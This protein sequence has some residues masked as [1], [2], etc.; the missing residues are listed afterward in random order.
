M[1][2]I[3]VSLLFLLSV[4]SA[5]AAFAGIPIPYG[6]AQKL[7]FVSE[8]EIR[9]SQNRLLSLC[10]LWTRQHL[11]YVGY[12]GSQVYVLAEN[13]CVD[14]GYYEYAQADLI[15]DRIA[16]IVPA[17][18]SDTPPINL[19]FLAYCFTAWGAAGII[20]LLWANGV[21]AE[22]S[23]LKRR[24]KLLGDVHPFVERMVTVMTH[25][26]RADGN[27]SDVEIELMR[28]T[29]RDYAGVPVS[30]EDIIRVINITPKIKTD[31]QFKE[32]GRGLDAQGRQSMF[33]AGLAMIAAD[34]ILH[35]S[36]RKWLARLGAGLGYSSRDIRTIFEEINA[37][38]QAATPGE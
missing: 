15:E 32:L 10:A 25:A 35:K 12:W 6:S 13:G 16:G 34:G 29:V 37:P 22:R 18:V 7:V 36:E 27:I 23:K 1:K 31:A 11:A 24:R 20:G 2:K 3:L 9:D 19:G 4:F 5:N 14:D 8:T 28:K 30:V 17:N 26:A 33:H 21:L 38:T